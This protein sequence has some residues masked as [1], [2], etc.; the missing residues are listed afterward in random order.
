MGRKCFK[1]IK[2][3]VNAILDIIYPVQAKCISCGKDDI[4][5][6]CDECREN[7]AYLDEEILGIGYYNKTL[8][9]LIIE[10]KGHKNFVAGNILV[11]L[12]AMKLQDYDR[13]YLLTYIPCNKHTIRTRGFNQCEYIARK[14]GSM[15]G[16]S[17]IDSLY[18]NNS[19]KIQKHL[20]KQE[21]IDNLRGAFI[22]KNNKDIIG[23]KIIVIDDVMTTGATLNEARRVLLEAKAKEVIVLALA[24]A[25]L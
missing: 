20:S 25:K 8:K 10:F 16:F 3:S 1:V 23:K 12:I 2:E 19:I 5:G 13:E 15:L 14:L 21:R 4:E 17:V 9:K 6:I 24:R 7:I 11:E 22:V 18:K